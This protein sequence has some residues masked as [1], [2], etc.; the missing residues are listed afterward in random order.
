L[1]LVEVDDNDGEG[2]IMK[3]TKMAETLAKNVHE[4]L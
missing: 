3:S 1:K 2:N 4:E